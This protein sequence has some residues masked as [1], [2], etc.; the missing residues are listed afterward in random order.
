MTGSMAGAGVGGAT[1]DCPATGRAGRRPGPG[2]ALWAAG[3]RLTPAPR[4]SAAYWRFWL[5]VSVVYELFLIF[6]LFQVSSFSVRW[7]GPSAPPQLPREA[8]LHPR[9]SGQRLWGLPSGHTVCSEGGW[10]PLAL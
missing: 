9:R 10:K 4:V 1:Q 3:P 8:R 2:G 5:C 7:G 6:I